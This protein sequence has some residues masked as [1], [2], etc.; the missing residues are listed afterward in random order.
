M[1]RQLKINHPTGYRPSDP[2]TLPLRAPPEILQQY[3]VATLSSSSSRP[4]VMPTI[5]TASERRA[6]RKQRELF[7]GNLVAGS[8]RLLVDAYMWLMAAFAGWV[9]GMDA[10]LLCS[11]APRARPLPRPHLALTSTYVTLM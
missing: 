1:G 11:A 2:P 4:A 9:R 3:R 10:V 6:E 7:V 8:V 5:V